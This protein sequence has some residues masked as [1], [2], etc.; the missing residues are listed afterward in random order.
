MLGLDHDGQSSK[1][2]DQDK[3]KQDKPPKDRDKNPS[4]DAPPTRGDPVEIRS[5]AGKPI[6][7]WMPGERLEINRVGKN[8]PPLYGGNTIKLD[9]N[10]TT[11]LT[12]SLSDV[13]VVVERGARAPGLTASGEILEA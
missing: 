5:K 13:N 3:S 11:T 2:N 9:P 1:S 8:K 4:E 12:G 6:G 10:K 7:T